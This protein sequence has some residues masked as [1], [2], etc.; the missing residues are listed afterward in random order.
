MNA[1]DGRT[2]T[3]DTPNPDDLEIMENETPSPEDLETMEGSVEPEEGPNSEASSRDK[4]M[5]A[6]LTSFYLAFR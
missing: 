6:F 5:L 2:A 1:L 3:Q 4:T